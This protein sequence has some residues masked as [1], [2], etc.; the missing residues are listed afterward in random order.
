MREHTA[1]ILLLIALVLPASARGMLKARNVNGVR[2]NKSGLIQ[3]S[4]MKGDEESL[5]GGG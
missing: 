5:V 3:V 4:E 2:T 1:L